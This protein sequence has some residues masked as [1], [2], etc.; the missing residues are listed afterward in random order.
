ML[1]KLMNGGNFSGS[2]F[3]QE[4][5]KKAKRQQIINALEI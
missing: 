2:S 5:I 1:K 4:D 3:L